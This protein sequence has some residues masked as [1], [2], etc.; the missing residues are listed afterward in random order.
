MLPKTAHALICPIPALFEHICQ[1]DYLNS[2]AYLTIRRTQFWQLRGNNSRAFGLVGTFSL[3]AILCG[4]FFKK[5]LIRPVRRVYS[6]DMLCNYSRNKGWQRYLWS[7]ITKFFKKIL[8]RVNHTSDKFWSC[9]SLANMLYMAAWRG[10][11][12]R[13]K[14]IDLWLW[15]R[16][17]KKIQLLSLFTVSLVPCRLF[18]ITLIPQPTPSRFPI[19]FFSNHLHIISFS[20][21]F[22][23]LDVD[24]KWS[25]VPRIAMMRHVISI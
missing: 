22:L 24:L 14:R 19:L 21:S 17:R 25:R 6:K 15:G 3:S 8:P 5:F 12:E 10:K 4:I 20:F 23:F 1:S 11:K 16:K 7:M 2:W 13:D 18:P 9:Q